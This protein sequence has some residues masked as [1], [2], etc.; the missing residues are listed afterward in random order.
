MNPYIWAALGAALGWIA[1]LSIVDK[2]A[3]SKVETIGIG[4]FGAEIGGQL[5]VTLAALAPAT[6]FQ[7]ATLL[8]A[9]A[10]GVAMLLLLGL[11]RG[12]IGPVKPSRKKNRGH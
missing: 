11:F 2:A 12:A 8:G 7:P 5:Q 10:G 3:M 1:T 6:D 9:A 4:I